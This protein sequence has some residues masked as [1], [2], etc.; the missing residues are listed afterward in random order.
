VVSTPTV[1][2]HRARH[3]ARPDGQAGVRDETGP[4][5]APRP[6]VDT[7]SGRGLIMHKRRFA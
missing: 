2:N 4:F 6:R 5:G 7:A 3:A 1:D